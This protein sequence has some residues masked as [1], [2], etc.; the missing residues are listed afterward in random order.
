M[1]SRPALVRFAAALTVLI[2][3]CCANKTYEVRQFNPG[4]TQNGIPFFPLEQVRVDETVYDQAWLDVSVSIKLAPESKE[5]DTHGFVGEHSK[6][7]PVTDI[8][9]IKT[10]TTLFRRDDDALSDIWTFFSLPGDYP[11]S[12]LAKTA[13]TN[14]GTGEV[15]LVANRQRFV[16]M[17]SIV[18]LSINSYVP[19][20][21]ETNNAFKFSTQGTLTEVSADVKDSFPGTATQAFASIAGAVVSA[22]IGGK[23]KATAGAPDAGVSRRPLAA[24][25]GG[26]VEPL[27]EPVYLIKMNI[28]VFHRYYIHRIEDWAGVFAGFNPSVPADQMTKIKLPDCCDSWTFRVIQGDGSPFAPDSPSAPTKPAATDN[29]IKIDGT[30]ELP[31]A[32]STSTPSSPQTPPAGGGTSGAGS[33]PKPPSK[34]PAK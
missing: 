10:L 6:Y 22:T 20:G 19:F 31:K 5:K 21:G 12:Q 17:P 30:I 3:A 27:P 9:S 33:Q 4:A 11:P 16:T 13:V 2:V 32:A 7:L 18:P 34:P 26:P 23:A 1:N 8:T 25:D 14:A 24:T 29:S 28:T 15:L